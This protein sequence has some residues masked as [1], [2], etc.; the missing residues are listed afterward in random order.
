MPKRRARSAG[1]KPKKKVITYPKWYFEKERI[2]KD[3]N[4]QAI[5]RENRLVK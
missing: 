2:E 4:V 3:Y 1:A 5:L